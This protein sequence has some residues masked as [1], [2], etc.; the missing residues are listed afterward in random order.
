MMNST[1]TFFFR[2]QTCFPTNLGRILLN[3]REIIQME[4]LMIGLV[5]FEIF[6]FFFVCFNIAK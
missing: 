1:T 5:L 6:S 4:Q 3:K 2:L